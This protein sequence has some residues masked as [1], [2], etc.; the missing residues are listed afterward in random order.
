M[1]DDEEEKKPK[2]YTEEGKEI[3]YEPNPVQDKAREFF[4]LLES[5]HG[6]PEIINSFTVEGAKFNCQ[7]LPQFSTVEDFS[8]YKQAMATQVA[9]DATFEI[10]CLCTNEEQ[11]SIFAEMSGTHTGLGGPCP[12]QNPPKRMSVQYCYTMHFNMANQLTELSMV[13][14]IFSMY[15]Q[16][17]W[18]LPGE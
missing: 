7:A 14:D 13:F 5:G 12:P 6:G 18:P 3:L 15:R 1:W 4:D 16:W 8:I 2:R 10:K 11:V 17:E 9:P